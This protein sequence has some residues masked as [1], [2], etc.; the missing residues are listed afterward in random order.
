MFSNSNSDLPRE[1]LEE[2]IGY[3][4]VNTSIAFIVLGIIFTVLRALARWQQKTPFMWADVLIPLALLSN[5]SLCALCIGKYNVEGFPAPVTDIELSCGQQ[6]WCWET[7]K[8]HYDHTTGGDPDLFQDL[9][10]YGTHFLLPRS[11]STK[12]SNSKY[13]P[14]YFRG[15]LVKVDDVHHCSH[16]CYQ[17]NGQ[18]PYNNLA[19]STHRLL[20]G[21]LTL[22]RALP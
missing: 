9:I 12:A 4:L 11:C 19:M 2:S 16:H 22:W 21:L 8:R 13:L 3:R 15:T 17:R 5:L 6:C 1:Y 18:Y 20:M 7:Y 10:Y 14:G